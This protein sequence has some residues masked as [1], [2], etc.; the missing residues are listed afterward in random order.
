MSD[1]TLA[2][3]V[4]KR[5]REA[6]KRVAPKSVPAPPSSCDDVKLLYSLGYTLF[7][8]GDYK[9]A[10]PLF[11]KLIFLAP[12]EPAY[13]KALASLYQATG[14]YEEAIFYWSLFLLMCEEDAMGHLHV[15]ECLISL[16]KL[17]EAHGALLEAKT[18]LKASHSDDELLGKIEVLCD[19]CQ[20]K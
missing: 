9:R 13:W 15:A 5:L 6:A 14:R 12:L 8:K 19:R 4:E 11:Q 16:G 10:E 7:E 20:P 17:E 1:N 3:H 18:H 2:P